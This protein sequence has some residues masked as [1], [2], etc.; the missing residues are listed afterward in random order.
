MLLHVLFIADLDLQ[1]SNLISEPRNWERVPH[2]VLSLKR[3]VAATNTSLAMPVCCGIVHM[4]T[5]EMRM[6]VL[7]QRCRPTRGSAEAHLDQQPAPS[8]S[9]TSWCASMVLVC[10]QPRVL[11]VMTL[12]PKPSRRPNRASCFTP[13]FLQTAASQMGIVDA[14]RSRRGCEIVLAGFSLEASR[15]TSITVGPT[16]VKNASVL[17]VNIDPATRR[18][19]HL[20]LRDAAR[21][22]KTFD[23]HEAVTHDGVDGVLVLRPRY[24]T[25]LAKLKNPFAE[26]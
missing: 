2:A 11:P 1:L 22:V 25:L 16:I 26:A 8:T 18:L 23:V 12:T 4:Y 10:E 9:M 7:D 14:C 13:C 15:T 17:Q 3:V 20:P 6:W 5:N 24:H 21:E 19:N